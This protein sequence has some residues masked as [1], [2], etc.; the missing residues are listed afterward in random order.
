MH[1]PLLPGTRLCSEPR[2]I[3][4]PGVAGPL[5]DPDP[6]ILAPYV[7]HYP[8]RKLGLRAGFRP[9]SNRENIKIG[10]S[11]GRRADFKAL[12][13]RIRPKSGQEPALRPGST[14]A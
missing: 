12:P 8:G 13:T 10:P 7:T 5:V 9:D 14:I 2:Y 11:A 1:G 4:V 3:Q 6:G